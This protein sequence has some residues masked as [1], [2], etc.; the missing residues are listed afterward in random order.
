M[1]AAETFMF[2]FKSKIKF[3]ENFP[4]LP[5]KQALAITA[6]MRRQFDFN[7]FFYLDPAATDLCLCTFVSGWQV[8]VSKRQEP[9][10]VIS[11]SAAAYQ[12]SSGADN[13]LNDLHGLCFLLLTHNVYVYVTQ[14]PGT[15]RRKN[16]DM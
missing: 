15:E 7:N 14:L 3:K 9:K 13:L 5:K 11:I 10:Q 6:V 4:D 16:K 1:P 2:C 12:T 8:R